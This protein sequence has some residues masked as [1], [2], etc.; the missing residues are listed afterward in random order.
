[1]SLLNLGLAL[2]GM[3]EKTIN[4]L[5]AQLPALERLA[6]AAK[7]VEPMI[8][9]LLPELNK[10]WPDVVAVTPVLQELI[11]F[12]KQKQASS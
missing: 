3:P 11:A 7:R 9:P 5:N 2:A 12:V 1:M 8:A 6:A 4:D 10:A